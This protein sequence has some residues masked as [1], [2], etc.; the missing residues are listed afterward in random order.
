MAPAIRLG[1]DKMLLISL[2]HVRTTPMSPELQKERE[3]AY[4]KPLFLLGKALNALMLDHT[5]YDLD[6]MQRLNA[7]LEAG[8]RAFGSSFVD[9]LSEELVR[10]R[11]APLRRIEAVHIRP[12]VDIGGLAAEFVHSGRVSVS[13]RMARS[14][15][16]RLASREAPHE[17]DLLSYLLFD[18]NYAAELIELGYQDA[19]R[20][21]EELGRLFSRPAAAESLTAG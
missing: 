8:E 10:L 9:L 11:G 13:G 15:I 7:I 2:R 14:V 1:A 18:G 6:R 12:S 16:S 17:S 19:A 20:K 3:E 5:D 21:E 4:P